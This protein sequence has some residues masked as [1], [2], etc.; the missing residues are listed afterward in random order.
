MCGNGACLSCRLVGSRL[1][2]RLV[3]ESNDADRRRRRRRRRLVAP[4]GVVAV[5]AI[6]V[7]AGTENRDRLLVRVCLRFDS[8]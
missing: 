7:V 4:D 2:D 6:A 5:G 8:L 3:G 1:V